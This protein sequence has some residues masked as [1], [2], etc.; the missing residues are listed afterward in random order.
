MVGMCPCAFRPKTAFARIKS[1]MSW[2]VFS[3]HASDNCI[4]FATVLFVRMVACVCGFLGF[5]GFGRSCSGSICRNSRC[6]SCCINILTLVS[7]SDRLVS[8]LFS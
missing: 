7:N 5:C 6:G 1:R 3:I 4:V 8:L 2:S